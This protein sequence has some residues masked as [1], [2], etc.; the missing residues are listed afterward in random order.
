M[1]HDQRQSRMGDNLYS[2]VTCIVPLPVLFETGHGTTD[3]TALCG[4]TLL[5]Y[6]TL[7]VTALT[8]SVCGGQNTSTRVIKISTHKHTHA[9]IASLLVGIG[10][11]NCTCVVLKE[12][13]RWSVVGTFKFRLVPP[14]R[15]GLRPMRGDED[16]KKSVNPAE[17]QKHPA[18]ATSRF[19]SVH[20]AHLRSY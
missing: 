1:S 7:S 6:S 16:T 8:C 9:C 14:F 13:P 19:S 12:T 11:R 15:W 17:I 5:L 2:A 20:L 10:W 3:C 18:L 4:T